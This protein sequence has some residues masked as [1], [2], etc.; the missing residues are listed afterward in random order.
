M[1]LW[2][3]GPV[4]GKIVDHYVHVHR[5]TPPGFNLVL[6]QSLKQYHTKV[7]DLSN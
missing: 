2:T 3:G 4:D 6:N 1:E 5:S 7:A